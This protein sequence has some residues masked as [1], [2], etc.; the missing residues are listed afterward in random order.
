M[1]RRMTKLLHETVADARTHEQDRAAEALLA[2]L[3]GSQDDC[4]FLSDSGGA[5]QLHRTD[6]PGFELEQITV[7]LRSKLQND[8]REPHTR[9]IAGAGCKVAGDVNPS[10]VECLFKF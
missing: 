1:I 4:G 3:N 2:F 10:A 6:C 8:D 7:A 9:G 5:G